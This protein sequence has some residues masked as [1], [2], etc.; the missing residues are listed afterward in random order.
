MVFWP[1]VLS[2]TKP[3]NTPRHEMPGLV[4]RRVK[5]REII[6]GSTKKL[7]GSTINQQKTM[8]KIGVN[9]VTN[10][11]HLMSSKSSLLSL[12]QQDHTLIY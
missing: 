8:K 5:K 6:K 4:K 7:L 9:Q 11:L 2:V 10:Q 1:L 3:L 12:T